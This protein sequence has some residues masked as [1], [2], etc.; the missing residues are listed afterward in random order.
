[1]LA[2]MILGLSAGINLLGVTKQKIRLVMRKSKAK[3]NRRRKILRSCLHNPCINSVRLM[4][5]GELLVPKKKF[6]HQKNN[7]ISSSSIASFLTHTQPLKL[8]TTIKMVTKSKLKM[9]LA[10]DKGVD[11]KKLHLKKKEKAARKDKS[12]KGGEKKSEQ[13]EW[14]DVE[15]E[16][17]G[18]AAL[19]GEDID[20]EEESEEE[21]NG[22]SNACLFL[23][24]FL[25]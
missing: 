19:E 24:Y 3:L 25:A 10:A 4:Q 16:E 14:E 13:E 15:S 1:M 17:D 6:P 5:G 11:Y 8:P 2:S 7:L 23:F 18:G 9:A 12:R 22:L 21:T 20:D